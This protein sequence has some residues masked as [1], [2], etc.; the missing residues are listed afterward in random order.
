MCEVEF[1]QLPVTPGEKSEQ[2][3]LQWALCVADKAAQRPGEWCMVL[4]REQ[5]CIVGSPECK[6]FD[7]KRDALY[8]LTIRYHYDF[9]IAQKLGVTGSASGELWIRQPRGFF[10]TVKEMFTK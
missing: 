2:E 6:E 9:A 5:A 8:D 3:D 7:R 4:R 10:Q 1:G